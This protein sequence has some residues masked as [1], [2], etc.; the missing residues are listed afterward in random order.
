M[1]ISFPGPL[2]LGA[3]Y[4]SCLGLQPPRPLTYREF[5]PCQFLAWYASIFWSTLAFLQLSLRFSNFHCA[6]T[7]LSDGSRSI[8][9]PFPASY[10]FL[11]SPQPAHKHHC[12]GKHSFPGSYCGAG[13]AKGFTMNHLGV[14]LLVGSAR[15]SDFLPFPLFVSVAGPGVS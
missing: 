10:S 5:S 6:S 1:R 12:I 7:S 2:R 8:A 14:L 15:G 3:S 9:S 11:L 13:K 4:D